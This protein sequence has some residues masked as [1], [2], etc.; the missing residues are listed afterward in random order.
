MKVQNELC[1]ACKD[2]M[3]FFV[4]TVK[5]LNKKM[6]WSFSRDS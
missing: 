1:S 5:P 2:P 3:F 6:F 4:H